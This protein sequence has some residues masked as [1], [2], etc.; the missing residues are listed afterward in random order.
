MARM[1]FQQVYILSV[2][3]FLELV[4]VEKPGHAVALYVPFL[5]EPPS[6]PGVQREFKTGRLETFDMPM[7]LLENSMSE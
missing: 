2:A 1:G 4:G 3:V 7:Y 6:D 5:R